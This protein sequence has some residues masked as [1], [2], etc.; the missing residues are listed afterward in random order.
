MT[1]VLVVD[2]SFFVRRNLTDIIERDPNLVVIDS[3]K[4]G[5]EALE[6]LESNQVDVMTLDVEMPEMNGLETLDEMNRRGIDCPVI[7]V[8]SLTTRGAESTAE[9]LEKGADDVIAKPSSDVGV[10][11]GEIE[12]KLHRTLN[13]ITRSQR[14]SS[15]RSD[16]RSSEHQVENPSD[17]VNH[18][19]VRQKLEK[20]DPKVV[21]IGGSTGAP[22]VLRTI[23]ET[24]PDDFP[25]PVAI[26]QHISEPFLSSLVTS[27]RDLTA[28]E[29]VQ[30]EQSSR[31]EPGT[32]YLPSDEAHLNFRRSS[33]DVYIRSRAGEPTQGAMPSVDVLFEQALNEYGRDVIAVLLTGM[34]E[35][36][37]RGMRAL[38]EEGALCL[39][40]DEATSTVYG[41][42]SAAQSLGGVDL[43]AP[44]ERIPS[45]IREW[46]DKSLQG[47]KAV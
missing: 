9:A 23:V 47:K 27:L 6:K 15:E 40:Q 11:L 34:G 21:V 5:L 35:D 25:L 42:P 46:T 14:S 1:N 26:V 17:D 13:A 19:S 18:E 8:S 24:L 7:V 38:R 29:V 45:I 39:A 2:D 30:V 36:G 43:E 37:A 33:N 3:A 31:V 10:D 20:V 22:P 41:M 12:R 44:A 28:M 32:I 4:N 16:E